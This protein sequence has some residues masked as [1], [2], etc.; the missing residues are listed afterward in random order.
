VKAINKH[1]NR[2]SRWLR[3]VK[4]YFTTSPSGPYI[5]EYSDKSVIIWLDLARCRLIVEVIPHGHKVNLN[6]AANRFQ[7]GVLPEQT[8]ATCIASPPAE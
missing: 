4:R 5:K 7:C 3:S 2:L 8:E 6:G 1:R